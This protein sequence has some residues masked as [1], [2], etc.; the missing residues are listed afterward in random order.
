MGVGR[1]AQKRGGGRQGK[2]LFYF[3]NFSRY[4]PGRG[5]VAAIYPAGGGPAPAHPDRLHS[6]GSVTGRAKTR[7]GKI[8]G[9]T[10]AQ[11]LDTLHRSA[12]DT[13]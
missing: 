2:R 10:A 6:A 8:P 3:G 11:T 12:L 13:R 1:F 9:Q 4:S 5:W 7:A